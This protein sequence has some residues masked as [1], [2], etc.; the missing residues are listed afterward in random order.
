MCNQQPWIVPA[1]IRAVLPP[2]SSHSPTGTVTEVAGPRPLLGLRRE[3]RSREQ[4]AG[5]R[6]AVGLLKCDL[7]K[8]EQQRGGGS[9]CKGPEAERSP[10]GGPSLVMSRWQRVLKA[11]TPPGR[12]HPKRPALPCRRQQQPP[13]AHHVGS[14]PR[15][16]PCPPSPQITTFLCSIPCRGSHVPSHLQG[17]LQ[18]RGHK[19][20]PQLPPPQ[21]VLD[22]HRRARLRLPWDLCPGRN[23]PP[24]WQSLPPF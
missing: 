21:T 3:L 14:A 6:R 11:D 24:L 5:L 13:K 12:P 20:F 17:L 23:R 7:R 8:G 16:G 18:T 19:P 22:T 15:P 9:K 2:V 10:G 4:E 1:S